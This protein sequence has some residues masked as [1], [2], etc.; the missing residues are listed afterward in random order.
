MRYAISE[1]NTRIHKLLMYLQTINMQQ[2][3]FTDTLFPN[4]EPR[5]KQVPMTL[6]DAVKDAI[7]SAF[8][9]GA[10]PDEVEKMARIGFG[11][12]ETR[13]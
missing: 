6:T 13:P 2:L 10:S 9:N 12:T 1:S 5:H 11:L 7:I 3:D 4:G 8:Y